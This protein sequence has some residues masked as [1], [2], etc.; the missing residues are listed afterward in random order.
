MWISERFV[1]DDNLDPP[2]KVHCTDLSLSLQS[3]HQW[4]IAA[5]ELQPTVYSKQSDEE[6]TVGAIESLHGI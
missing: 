4:I 1:A 2:E 3:I 5:R 6:P